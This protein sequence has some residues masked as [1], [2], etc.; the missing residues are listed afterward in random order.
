MTM[1]RRRSLAT[2]LATVDVSA[3]HTQSH[4]IAGGVSSVLSSASSAA[5]VEGGAT[6]VAARAKRLA[7]SLDRSGGRLCR[8]PRA[9]VPI[10]STHVAEFCHPNGSHP[11]I[12]AS[13]IMAS[14]TTISAEISNWTRLIPALRTD[15]RAN[16]KK[17]LPVTIPATY[18]AATRN[19]SGARM[20]NQR[21]SM[22]TISRFC[23][24]KISV[25]VASRRTIA[26][27][28]HRIYRV[29]PLLR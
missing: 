27:Y 13:A 6:R 10:P 19:A 7:E 15:L 17:L 5:A 18:V 24:A 14:S 4:A 9:R 20:L 23:R 3:T 16:A 21:K 11:S 2:V 1:S 12:V 22:L 29:S 8:G 25:A 28:S 26:T